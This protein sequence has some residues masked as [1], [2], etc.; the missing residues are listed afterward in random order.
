MDEAS[1][2]GACERMGQ[3][4]PSHVGSGAGPIARDPPDTAN[5]L[6]QRLAP[7]DFQR[8]FPELTRVRLAVGDRLAS[9]GEPIEAACFLEGAIAG[10]LDVL[11]DERRIAVGIVGREGFVGWPLLMG[12]DRWPYDVVVRAAPTTA[13]RVDASALMDLVN[14]S[15]PARDLLLRYAGVFMAQMGRTIVS[16]LINSIDRRTARWLLLY[17]DRIVGDEIAVTHEELS[18][19][20]GVRRSSVTDALHILEGE[21]LIESLRGRVV[22]RD[23]ARL[24]AWASQAYGFAEAEYARLILEA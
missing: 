20:L 6:L 22:I 8:L 17:D 16:N 10:F 23:R 14:E 7:P 13:L 15:R 4:E 5:L 3:P 21:G 2:A 12:N 24:C 11:D 19:M 9:A 1:G 18:I